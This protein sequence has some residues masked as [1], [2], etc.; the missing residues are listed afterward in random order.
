[1]LA[2]LGLSLIISVST[3]YYVNKLLNWV[4]V[5][6]EVTGPVRPVMCIN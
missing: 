5:V 4:F 2:Y 3:A 1:M 6:I